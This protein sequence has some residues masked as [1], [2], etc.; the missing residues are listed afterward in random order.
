MSQGVVGFSTYD[1]LTNISQRDDG[2]EVRLGLL[3]LRGI[4]GRSPY[5]DFNGAGWRTSGPDT[6]SVNFYEPGSHMYVQKPVA[7][8]L[9]AFGPRRWSR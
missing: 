2:P 3:Y 1:V 4:T 8:V 7:E 6:P 9:R 5:R